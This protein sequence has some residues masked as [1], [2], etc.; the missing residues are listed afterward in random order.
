MFNTVLCCAGTSAAPPISPGGAAAP[1]G[2][3]RKTMNTGKA[4]AASDKRFACVH[5]RCDNPR[6]TR[7]TCQYCGQRN[8]AA[9]DCAECGVA[10]HHPN[11]SYNWPCFSKYHSARS[12]DRKHCYADWRAQPTPERERAAFQI[13]PDV[14]AVK[15]KVKTKQQSPPA[16]TRSFKVTRETR[17]TSSTA[18]AAPQ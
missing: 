13:H 9:Y 10:L 12:A 7:G 14:L 3:K 4:A 17:A 2:Q 6:K 8:S 15:N 11:S 5:L 16:G 1:H 18:A